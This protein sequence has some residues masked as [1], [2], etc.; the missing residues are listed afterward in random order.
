ML[1]S[2]LYFY[3]FEFSLKHQGEEFEQVVLRNKSKK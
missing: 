3:S 2:T 1:I